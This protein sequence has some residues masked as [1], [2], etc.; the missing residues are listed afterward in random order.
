[1][2]FETESGSTY[3]IRGGKIR[4][5]N[6]ASGK[7]ADGFWIGLAEQPTVKVGFPVWI[8][9]ESLKDFGPDDYGNENVGEVTTRVTSPVTRI[10]ED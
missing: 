2:R 6:P 9:M 8:V 5:L 1:M 7:R 4:R 10:E 3:E